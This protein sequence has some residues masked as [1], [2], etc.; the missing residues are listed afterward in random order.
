MCL[1][2][3]FAAASDVSA[4]KMGPQFIMMIAYMAMF[5]VLSNFYSGRVVARYEFSLICMIFCSVFLPLSFFITMF[6]FM[7]TTYFC[8]P[9]SLSLC[10][11]FFFSSLYHFVLS[12]PSPSF[13]PCCSSTLVS[14]SCPLIDSPLSLF[15]CFKGSPIADSKVLDTYRWSPSYLLSHVVAQAMISP[16]ARISSFTFCRRCCFVRLHCVCRHLRCHEQHRYV[17][18]RQ[19]ESWYATHRVLGIW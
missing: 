12:D 5:R 1:L 10:S 9:F 13:F 11:F 18:E 8:L 7:H 6:F 16:S 14:H 17:Q 4:G 19:Q 2:Q 3:M 15:R